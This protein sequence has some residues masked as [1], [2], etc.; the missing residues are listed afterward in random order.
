VHL[1]LALDG[2]RTRA[3]LIEEMRPFAGNHVEQELDNSLKGLARM[4]LLE[5]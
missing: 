1:L 4:A 3:A 2:S 5:A